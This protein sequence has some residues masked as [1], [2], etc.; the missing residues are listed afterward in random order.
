ME[1]LSND[2]IFGAVDSFDFDGNTILPESEDN[3]YV[4]ISGFDFFKF[5]TDDKIMDY[6]SLMG[7]NM[8]PFTFAIGEKQTY[9]LS[10][11]Y[12][13]FGNDKIKEGTLLDTSNNSL[14]PFDYHLKKCG[15]DS[16][17]TLERSQIRTFWPHIEEEAEDGDDVLVDTNYRNGNNEVVKNFNQKCVICYEN[18]GVYAFRQ[19]G[20]QCIFERYYENEGVID[21]L[22]C[23]VCKK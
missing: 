21:I 3:G 8:C 14:D 19:C 9:F 23:V 17:K 15:V 11:H 1:I 13:F 4:Y 22:K 10:T 5:K 2:R 7:K 12:K 16:L 6:I 18:D 20:R